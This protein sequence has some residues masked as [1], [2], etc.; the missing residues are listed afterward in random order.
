MNDVIIFRTGSSVGKTEHFERACTRLTDDEL[1][2]TRSDLSPRDDKIVAMASRLWSTMAPA[3]TE[4]FPGLKWGR[5][6]ELTFYE[7][8]SIQKRHLIDIAENLVDLWESANILSPTALLDQEGGA[9][10]DKRA[11]DFDEIDYSTIEPNGRSRA[12]VVERI[13]GN[14]Q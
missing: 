5:H 12:P 8:N 2:G 9:G 7:L 11:A 10:F 3:S 4:L 6:L 14:E 13:A 1:A